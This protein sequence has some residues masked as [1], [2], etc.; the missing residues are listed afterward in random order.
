MVHNSLLVC[1]LE[2]V[3][4]IIQL[5]CI[6][7]FCSKF[8][9]FYSETET[10]ILFFKMGL[11]SGSVCMKTFMEMNN[12]NSFSPSLKDGAKLMSGFRSDDF[13]YSLFTGLPARQIQFF[14]LKQTQ[15]LAVSLGFI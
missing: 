3:S 13:H 5:L 12:M 2:L 15:L 14:L 1:F 7:T 6:V 10:S 8:P 9:L 4:L 11:V